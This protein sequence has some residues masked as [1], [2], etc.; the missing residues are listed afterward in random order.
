MYGALSISERPGFRTSRFCQV[1]EKAI[2]AG[3]VVSVVEPGT[4]VKEG[5]VLV[6]VTSLAGAVPVSYTH[7]D[8]YKRQEL[9][10]RKIVLF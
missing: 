8:V 9:V 4:A 3:T 5:D 7:L 2:M 6:T 10:N 1:E